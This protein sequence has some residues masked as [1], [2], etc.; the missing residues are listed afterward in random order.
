M[1]KIRRI[2]QA[3]AQEELPEFGVGDT[4]DVHVLIREGD[5]ERIQIFNG[6][7]IRKRGEGL[8]ATYTVRRIVQGQGVERI[9]PLH[10]P[11]VKKVVVK[12]SGK[13]R[14]SRLYYLRERKGKGTR[15][16]EIL[17]GRPQGKKAAPKREPT[18]APEPETAEE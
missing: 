16:K 4:V 1:S 10:S 7:V 5:K 12:R 15:L 3:Y 17:R 9:F 11:F 8:S 6:T 2:E 14:R 13:V 18:P